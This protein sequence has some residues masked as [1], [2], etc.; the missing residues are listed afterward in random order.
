MIEKRIYKLLHLDSL[1]A[2][3]LLLICKS[4]EWIALLFSLRSNFLAMMAWFAN[5]C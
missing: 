3:D 5:C 2:I 1:K 4:L